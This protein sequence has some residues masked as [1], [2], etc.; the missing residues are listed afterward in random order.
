MKEK[1]H[2][3]R[4]NQAPNG[5]FSPLD[6]ILNKPVLITLKDIINI[7]NY[8]SEG[9][10][11]TTKLKE[12]YPVKEE[13]INN[14]LINCFTSDSEISNFIKKYVGNLETVRPLA[15]VERYL[16]LDHLMQFTK[17]VAKDLAK[18]NLYK[19]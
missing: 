5:N 15:E 6:D 13:D 19:V 3:P 4:P 14:Y 17:V 18:Q 11:I 8:T 16:I 7:A 12:L 10:P 2:T 9:K 1:N